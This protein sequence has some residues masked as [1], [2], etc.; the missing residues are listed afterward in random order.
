[1]SV[2]TVAAQ[3]SATMLW[4]EIKHSIRLLRLLIV[5]AILVPV[6]MLL[7]FDYILGGAIG[8]GLGAAS[9]ARAAP[10]AHA[11]A[12]AIQSDSA[13]AATGFI[14]ISSSTGAEQAS[15]L[16]LFR[17]RE[18]SVAWQVRSNTRHDHTLYSSISSGS[19][20]APRP[21]RSGT[22]TAPFTTG[23]EFA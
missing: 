2:L 11:G 17:M 22:S 7:L 10:G 5:S 18:I 9:C 15:S 23:T 21:A 4:R 1:M 13:S 20:S 14:E 19:G 12:H 6:V 16:P 3:D 8:Q